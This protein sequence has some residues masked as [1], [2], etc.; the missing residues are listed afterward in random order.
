MHGH[1][2]VGLPTHIGALTGDGDAVSHRILLC[3]KM[4]TTY[5]EF[6]AQ[7]RYISHVIDF[8]TAFQDSRRIL[9]ETSQNSIDKLLRIPRR[10]T[11]DHFESFIN[12]VHDHAEHTEGPE[13]PEG[14]PWWP[15]TEEQKANRDVV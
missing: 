11:S 12:T 1:K 4:E 9:E 2:I 10:N 13:E 5:E 3:E 6:Q 14:E 8:L 15:V 7:Y